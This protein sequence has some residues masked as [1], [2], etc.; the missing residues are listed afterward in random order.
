MQQLLYISKSTVPGDGADLV[1]ILQQSRHNNAIDGV[2][3]LLWSDGQF[4]LQVIEGPEESV[5]SCFHRIV[6]DARHSEIR[7]IQERVVEDREFHDWTMAHR[8]AS[9]PADLYDAQMRRLVKNAHPPIAAAFLNLV[10]HGE[11]P[12]VAIGEA[13]E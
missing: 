13:T 7:I 6:S 9:E 1:G 11:L 4:F 2:T 5:R 8:R 3:G 10:A 12:S